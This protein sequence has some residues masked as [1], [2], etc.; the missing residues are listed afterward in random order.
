MITS[1]QILIALHT[2]LYPYLLFIKH[3]N[4][5]WELINTTLS[6]SSFSSSGEMLSTSL[7]LLESIS[8]IRIVF[9]WMKKSF[10]PIDLQHQPHLLLRFWYPSS[11][12]LFPNALMLI[13][14]VMYLSLY[15][16]QLFSEYLISGTTTASLSAPSSCLFAYFNIVLSV[17]PSVPFPEDIHHAGSVESHRSST[18]AVRPR[19]LCVPWG[20]EREAQS[21]QM[22][23][24]FQ[25]CSHIHRIM[26]S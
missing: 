12:F 2:E 13:S 11:Y 6:L 10:L 9:F 15:L 14:S 8:V 16:T 1:F 23:D 20:A 22:E 7:S 24:V 18:A 4:S 5:P 25:I 19:A 3:C 21:P 26:E 17:A